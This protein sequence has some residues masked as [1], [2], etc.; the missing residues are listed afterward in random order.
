MPPMPMPPM[1]APP[2]MTT[3]MIGSASPPMTT[4]TYATDMGNSTSV[5]ASSNCTTITPGTPP[6]LSV[7]LTLS[8]LT[9]KAKVDHNDAMVEEPYPGAAIKCLRT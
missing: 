9:F 4:A 1:P 7:L 6:H 8:L 5:S 2:P 3:S